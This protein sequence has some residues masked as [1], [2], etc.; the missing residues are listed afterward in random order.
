VVALVGDLSRPRLGLGADRFDERA[1]HADLI[2]HAAADNNLI[3]PYAEL[4]AV[5]VAG[6]AELIRLACRY[7]GIPVH[8]VS[9]IAVLAGFGAAGVRAVTEDTPLAFPEYLHMGYTETKWVAEALLGQAGR[10]GLTVGIHRVASPPASATRALIKV[11]VDSGVS[12]QVELPLDF[13]PVDLL[14]HLAL[15][16]DPGARTYRLAGQR[17]ARLPEMADRLRA[18]GYPVVDL[19]PADWVRRVVEFIRERPD[20]PFAP[21]VPLWVDRSPRS[22]LVPAELFFAARFPLFTVTEPPMPPVDAEV[23]DRYVP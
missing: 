19:P 22:G 3:Y 18:A 17:P 6:T 10:A 21:F 4:A 1:R 16:Q 7:R 13:V 12:P 2:L 5:T 15:T 8:L 11:I 20:H 14:V 23:L 9:T